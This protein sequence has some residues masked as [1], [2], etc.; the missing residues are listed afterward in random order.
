MKR[1]YITTNLPIIDNEDLY[2]EKLINNDSN[3]VKSYNYYDYYIKQSEVEVLSKIINIEYCQIIDEFPEFNQGDYIIEIH[4]DNTSSDYYC[5]ITLEA[6]R[7]E[8]GENLTDSEC[9]K[10]QRISNLV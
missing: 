6:I 10:I 9:R 8:Y 3:K 7:K 2:F 4:P 1:K 5:N